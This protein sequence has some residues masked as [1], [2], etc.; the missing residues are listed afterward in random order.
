MRLKA[1]EL[2]YMK[3]KAMIVLELDEKGEIKGLTRL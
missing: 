3:F 2:D 1:T